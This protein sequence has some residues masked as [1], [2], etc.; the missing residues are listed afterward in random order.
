MSACDRVQTQCN[1]KAQ[2]FREAT[3][4]VK[5]CIHSLGHLNKLPHSIDRKSTQSCTEGQGLRRFG[6]RN[7]PTDHT[8][9]RC[10]V[11]QFRVAP[12]SQGLQRSAD[13]LLLRAYTCVLHNRS[14]KFN[15]GLH[16]PED[17]GLQGFD[18]PTAAASAHTHTHARACARELQNTQIQGCTRG[19]RVTKVWP[20]TCCC[21]HTHAFVAE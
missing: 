19:S 16:Q 1:C 4:W 10:R 2:Y 12:K 9:V 11:Y 14:T 20:T 18:R 3:C 8:H 21:E 6:R 17:Q 7:A 13:Q 15:Q 5:H